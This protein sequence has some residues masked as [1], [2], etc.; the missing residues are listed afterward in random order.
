MDFDMITVIFSIT[1]TINTA[2]ILEVQNSEKRDV[3]KN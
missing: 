2:T 3:D 1:D